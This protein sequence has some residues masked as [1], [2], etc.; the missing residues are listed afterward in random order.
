M[1]GRVDEVAHEAPL[2]AAPRLLLSMG[3]DLTRSPIGS[4]AAAEPR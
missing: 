4:G 3:V 1:I 2:M